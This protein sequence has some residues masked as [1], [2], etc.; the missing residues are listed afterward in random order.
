M[1]RFY[2]LPLNYFS[3]KKEDRDAQG[4]RVRPK[5]PQPGSSRSAPAPHEPAAHDPAQGPEAGLRQ[6]ARSLMG[7]DPSW[8]GH[9]LF[10]CHSQGP[11]GSARILQ[12]PKASA[13]H[14]SELSDPCCL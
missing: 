11:G 9:G 8:H 7:S 14:V 13:I 3:W 6:P 12:A 5:L 4:D 10:L 2:R 1:S